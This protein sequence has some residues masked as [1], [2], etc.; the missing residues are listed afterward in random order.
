MAYSFE[1]D[2][3]DSYIAKLA[4]PSL[5]TIHQPIAAMAYEAI[6][7]IARGNDNNIDRILL[8]TTLIIRDSA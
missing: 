6:S 5:T 3:D 7:V 8:P 2:S 4:W 1:S